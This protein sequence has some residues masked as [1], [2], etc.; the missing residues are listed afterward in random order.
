M[1]LPCSSRRLEP[2]AEILA[3]LALVTD[4]GCRAGRR[5]HGQ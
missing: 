1:I 2:D 4:N 3:Q 5:S